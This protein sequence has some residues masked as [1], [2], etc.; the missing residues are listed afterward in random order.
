MTMTRKAKET[1]GLAYV[2]GYESPLPRSSPW[3]VL[4][5]LTLALFIIVVALLLAIIIKIA[6][7]Y[8]TGDGDDPE[9][10]IGLFVG[11][12]LMLL[13]LA[14]SPLA[15]RWERRRRRI[16][17]RDDERE[18][19]TAYNP[20]LPLKT[21]EPA[22]LA[23]AETPASPTST[24]W[25]RESVTATEVTANEPAS[26]QS[27]TVE[28]RRPAAAASIYARSEVPPPSYQASARPE[29][30]SEGSGTGSPTRTEA[31]KAESFAMPKGWHRE[32]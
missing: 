4:V 12:G 10:M 15:F 3:R 27:A 11:F 32:E 7:R 1:H 29:E 5:A 23:A 18:D 8:G 16:E 9:D 21:P 31:T 19:Y 25:R 2:F 22:S 20:P 14:L 28:E 6:I 30:T 13:L 24:A 17:E 26:E